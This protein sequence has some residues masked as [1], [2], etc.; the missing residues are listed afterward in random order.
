M[1]Y[2]R[3]VALLRPYT[4]LIGLAVVALGGGR[5]RADQKIDPAVGFSDL[6]PIG[7]AVSADQPLGIVHAATPDSAVGAIEALRSA[8]TIGDGAPEVPPVVGETLLPRS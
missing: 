2:R 6:A 4:G 8:Y 5:T 3:L 7:A 1:T